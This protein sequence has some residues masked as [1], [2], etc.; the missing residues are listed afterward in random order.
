[1]IWLCIILLCLIVF[2]LWFQIHKLQIVLASVIIKENE[3]LIKEIMADLNFKG[4]HDT[5]REE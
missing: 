2:W 4:G 3:N 1:M 5:E